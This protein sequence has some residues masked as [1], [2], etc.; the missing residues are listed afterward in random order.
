MKI[1]LKIW[2]YLIIRI[3]KQH[4]FVNDCFMNTWLHRDFVGQALKWIKGHLV[5]NMWLLLQCEIFVIPFL[6]L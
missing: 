6:L 5:G 4:F 3:A 2:Q 1:T